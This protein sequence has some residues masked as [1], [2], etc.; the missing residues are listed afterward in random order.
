MIGAKGHELVGEAQVPAQL[1]AG[2]HCVNLGGAPFHSAAA[3]AA[4]VLPRPQQGLHLPRQRLSG[5]CHCWRA[6][7]F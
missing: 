6:S 4:A 7:H 3:A 5:G 2:L 1:A